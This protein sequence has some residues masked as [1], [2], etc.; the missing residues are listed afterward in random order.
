MIPRPQALIELHASAEGCYAKARVEGMPDQLPCEF[1]GAFASREEAI[2][3]ATM[4][5]V[6]WLRRLSCGGHH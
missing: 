3:E 5:S 4:W 1:F 6:G 2:R